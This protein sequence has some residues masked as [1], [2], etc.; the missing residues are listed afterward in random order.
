M[1]EERIERK[2]K[3]ANEQLA[4]WQQRLTQAQQQIMQWQVVRKLCAELL[5]PEP[6]P[7]SKPN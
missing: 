4:I 3:E 1:I 2:A 7:E 5:E 6:E